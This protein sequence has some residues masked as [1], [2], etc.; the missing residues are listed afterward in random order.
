MPIRSLIK[1]TLSLQGFRGDSIDRHSFG[2]NI[3]IV[4]HRRYRP[5][6]GKCGHTGKYRDTRPD[7][8]V[9]SRHSGE[10]R[11]PETL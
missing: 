4:P 8:F 2:L 10:N 6:C 3:K 5:R 9:K 1:E 11:S 7:G